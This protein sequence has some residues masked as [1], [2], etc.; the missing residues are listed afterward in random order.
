MFVLLWWMTRFEA[1]EIAAR[2]VDVPDDVVARERQATERFQS[3]AIPS[4]WP[5]PSG[6]ASHPYAI[7]VVDDVVWL[8]DS[9]VGVSNGNY[10]GNNRMAAQVPFALGGAMQADWGGNVGY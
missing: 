2:G 1:A 10:Y 8:R 6:P 3:R 5:S 4:E 9:G 7:E